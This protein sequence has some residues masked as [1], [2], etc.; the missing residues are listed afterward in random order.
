MQAE[1]EERKKLEQQLRQL[2]REQQGVKQS[3]LRQMFS[4]VTG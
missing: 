2:R 3:G 1:Q 4:A